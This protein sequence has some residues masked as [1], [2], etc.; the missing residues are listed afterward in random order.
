VVTFKLY[1]E[2]GGEGPRLDTRF[3]EAWQRF[4]RRAGLAG[5]MPKVVRGGGRSQTLE[6]FRTA[7]ANPR[8]GEVPLLLLDSEGPVAQGCSVWAHLRSLDDWA[9]PAGAGDDQAFLMV[10]IMET[11]LLADRE[12]LKRYFGAGFRADALKAWPRLESVAK[13]TVLKALE[14]ASAGCAMRYSKGRVSFDLLGQIDP[15]LVGSACPH[16]CALLD[17]LRGQPE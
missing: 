7:L 8:R 12:A 6:M 16:A 15:G 1:I 14:R 17:R 11:W 3:R 13:D 4:F 9:Q 10:Q 5:R 2:G